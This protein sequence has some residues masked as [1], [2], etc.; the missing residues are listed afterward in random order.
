MP[1]QSKA[2]I[3]KDGGKGASQVCFVELLQALY[4][5]GRRR[6]DF[7]LAVNLTRWGWST[8][9]GEKSSEFCFAHFAVV[10]RVYGLEHLVHSLDELSGTRGRA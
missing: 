5:R 8:F 6:L 3:S 9:F 4:R 2:L 10:A 1:V 7:R